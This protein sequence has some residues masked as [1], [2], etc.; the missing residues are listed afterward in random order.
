MNV[1]PNLFPDPVLTASIYCHGHLDEV[2]HEA[3][4]PF[5]RRFREQHPDDSSYIWVSRYVRRGEHIKVRIHGPGELRETLR[6]GLSEAIERFFATLGPADETG[7]VVSDD[8][9]PLDPE[10]EGNDLHPDRTLLW[11]SYRRVPGVMGREPTADDPHLAALFT[12]C[13]ARGTE[14]VLEELRPGPDGKLTH[15]QRSSLVLKFLVAGLASLDL[16]NDQRL[17]YLSYHRD[18]LIIATESDHAGM[19]ERFD[20]KAS[21]RS[22]LQ[23]LAQVFEAQ[24]AISPEEQTDGRFGG[25]QR[26][27][28]DLF[29]YVVD[30]C[31]GASFDRSLYWRDQAF[32]PLFK[33]LHGIANQIRVG[34]YN[35]AYLVHLL[36][37][38]LNLNEASEP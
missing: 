8:L 31:G 13:L 15:Q 38:S 29:E 26:S 12:R 23:N 17:D 19:L 10:D 33:I 30:V 28:I 27:L 36:L 20:R 16:R 11:T 32:A 24:T 25:W 9:H 3:L 14:I 35:E 37:L 4:S 1:P 21:D 6:S 7:R 34:I 18:W 22:S 5:W 2:L